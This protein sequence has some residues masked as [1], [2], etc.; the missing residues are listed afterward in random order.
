MEGDT[1]MADLLELETPTNWRKIDHV[2]EARESSAQMFKNE[3]RSVLR[4]IFFVKRVHTIQKFF[5]MCR[6]L[7]AGFRAEPNAEILVYSDEHLNEPVRSFSADYVVRQLVGL[8]SQSL[9]LALCRLME[10]MGFDVTEEVDQRDVGADGKVSLEELCQEVTDTSLKEGS[11]TTTDVAQASAL[12]TALESAW[13][14][15]Q[16][17][18]L[19]QH[20]W[21]STKSTVQRLQLYL[22]AH[23]WLHED[24]LM[25]GA[26]LNIMNPISKELFLNSYFYS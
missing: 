22:T 21:E 6:V 9:A 24:Y 13:K 19:I 15:S 26:G 14:R 10:K 20:S 16:A 1:L 11:V 17:A 4:D 18:Q 8:G 7:G 23:N 2:R 5:T 25:M 3:A 12:C